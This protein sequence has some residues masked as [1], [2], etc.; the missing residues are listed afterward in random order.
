M[1][2]ISIASLFSA[3]RDGEMTDLVQQGSDLQFKVVLPKLAGLRIEGSHHFLCALAD[4]RE[5]SLQPFRNESTE[6]KDLKQIGKLQLRIE[7]GEATSGQQIKVFCSH[8]AGGEARL[9]FK[10]ALFSVWDERFD[11][12]TVADLGILRGQAAGK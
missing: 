5:L 4:V 9:S 12:V 1:E 3:L 6:I 2:P 8:R 11:V 10:A 7:R